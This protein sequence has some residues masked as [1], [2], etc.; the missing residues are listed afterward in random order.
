M[1]KSVVASAPEKI[2]GILLCVLGA[3]LLLYVG[4]WASGTVIHWSFDIGVCF[5]LA[6]GVFSLAAGVLLAKGI[7]M[8]WLRRH[9]VTRAILIAALSLFLLTFVAAE[10]LVIYSAGLNQANRQADFLLVPG[11]SVVDGRPSLILKHRLDGA[12]PWL[13]ANPNATV[14]VSGGQGAGETSTEASVMKQYLAENGI[15]LN[16]IIEEDQA[17]NT[18]ENVAFSKRIM[19]GLSSGGKHTVMIVTSDF[20]MFRALLLARAQGVHALGISVPVHWSVKP[21]CYSREYF[22]VM[23][24]L[25]TGLHAE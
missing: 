24:L 2:F 12:I 17:S 5:L 20:H 3:A 1:S 10:S 23:K 9:K 14:I 22:S 11:A 13:K 7:A 21:I 8:P 18:I 15:E 16:R 19:D 4:V 6:G 25:L